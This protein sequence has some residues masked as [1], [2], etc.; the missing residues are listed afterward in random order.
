MAAEK[1]STIEERVVA[2]AEQLGRIIGTVQGK[3]DGWL[4]KDARE[5]L[6][7]IRDGASNLLNQLGGDTQKGPTP[8]R[9]RKTAAAKGDAPAPAGR[10]TKGTSRKRAAADRSGGAVDAP[11]KQHRKPSASTRGAK[12]SDTRIA[13]VKAVQ[14]MRRGG[15]RRG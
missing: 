8:S 6:T 11:G 13:K 15:P 12:H 9:A 7:E 10:A 4:G 1:D 3:A 5:Q 2:F 14:T